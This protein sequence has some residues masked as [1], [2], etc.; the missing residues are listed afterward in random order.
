MKLPDAR[1]PLGMVDANAPGLPRR[2]IIRSAS[3]NR[4]SEKGAAALGSNERDGVLDADLP[5][6]GSANHAAPG[7]PFP[8]RTRM[9]PV[10]PRMKSRNSTRR[11]RFLCA[12]VTLPVAQSASARSEA[13][14]SPG[15][16]RA[17]PHRRSRWRTRDRHQDL[18][19]ARSIFCP[20]RKRQTYCTST[21][22]S[23][24]A[25]SGPDQRA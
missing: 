5:G 21:S 4:G 24:A 1:T 12:A 18:R 25:N 16:A 19:P 6:H 17:R 22:P 3:R 7:T 13:S 23:A 10:A 11:R 20:R 8:V 2:R 15:H 9:L 14:D